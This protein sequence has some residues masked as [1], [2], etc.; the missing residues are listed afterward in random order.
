MNPSNEEIKM[1]EWIS[2]ASYSSLL[3][4]W[5]FGHSGDEHFQG[6]IGDHY[7]REMA[8]KKNALS[9]TEQIQISKEIG[10]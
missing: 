2:N 9:N 8:R 7:V 4:K 10:W 3:S 5:R 6:M 1:I